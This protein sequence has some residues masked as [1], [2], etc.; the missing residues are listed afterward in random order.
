MGHATRRTIAGC[1]GAAVLAGGAVAAAITQSVDQP[2]TV[3]APAERAPVEFGDI[4][5]VFDVGQVDA[6]VV[7][8]SA[9]VAEQSGGVATGGRTGSLGLSQVV[10]SGARVGGP[11]VGYLTPVT[12]IAFPSP[13]IGWLFGSDVS[14][15]VGVRTIALNTATA[16]MIGARAG[17][18]LEFDL[19]DGD[20][21]RLTV[22]AVLDR[23]VLGSTEIAMTNETAALVG[24]A[25]DTRVVIWGFED[26]DIFDAAVHASGLERRI[27]TKVAR[28]WDTKDPDGTLGTL[29]T[30]LLLGQPW[31]RFEDDG[32]MEMH[33]TWKSTYLVD[34]RQ[35][36]NS[37][38]PVYARCHKLVMDDLRGAFA[39]LVTAGLSAEIDV[40]NANTYGGC[41]VARFSRGSGYLSRHAYGMAFDT[42]TSANCQG[43]VPAMSCDVVRIFRKHGFAWGGN[44]RAPDGMHFEWVGERRDQI[45]Y[46]SNYCSN[47][48]TV[49]P[50]VADQ[51]QQPSDAVLGID[52]LSVGATDDDHDHDRDHG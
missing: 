26:R 48:V 45:P 52:V 34:G 49:Q 47:I 10:R 16:E 27:D 38:I 35:L 51:S 43:C 9:R 18:E 6:A 39:E 24:Y 22:G 29:A 12:F 31:Y 19:V 33:P 28:S 50:Q 42:N 1:V 30:K 40:D 17:D 15:T 8:A 21:V 37:T 2:A 36:V 32:S 46:D 4:A 3:D 20:L 23:S 11:P 25:V 5:S 41:Y 14:A 13:A 44:F 7:S